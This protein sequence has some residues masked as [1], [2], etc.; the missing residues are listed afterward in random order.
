MFDLMFQFLSSLSVSQDLV[1]AMQTVIFLIIKKP[2]TAKQVM[3][4]IHILAALWSPP[5][6]AYQILVVQMLFAPFHHKDTP[7]ASVPM[8][9]LEI[10]PVQLVVEDQNAEQMMTAQSNWPVLLTSV[11][12]P[13][14][15]H[16][17]LEQCVVLKNIILSAHVTM[18]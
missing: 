16:V 9:C 15:A 4:E 17:E 3:K 18:V 10:P 14:L 8:E 7:C 6:P 5:T 2:A 11:V 1:V 13:A 12:I